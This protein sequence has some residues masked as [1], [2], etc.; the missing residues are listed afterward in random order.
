MEKNIAN[1]H[2]RRKLGDKILVTNDEGS[3]AFLSQDDYRSLLS[4]VEPSN[5]DLKAKHLLLDENNI[6]GSV[7]KTHNRYSFL[8]SG[9]PLHIIVPTLRCN[10]KCRYC[11][12]SSKK[13][14]AE[15][16]DMDEET[17][18]STVDFIM[19]SPSKT[20]II[21]FQGGEPLLNFEIVRYIIEY[22]E[23]KIPAYKTLEFRLVTNFSLMTEEIMEFLLEHKVN[24]CTSIDGP[25]EVNDNIRF[26]CDGSSAYE[27]SSY[28]L[29]KINKIYDERGIKKRVYSIVTITRS[30]LDYPKEIVDTYRDL[31]IDMLH[32]RYVNY[33]GDA[34]AA[35]KDLNYSPDEFIDYWK[36]HVEYILEL[37]KQG[38][39]VIERTIKILLQKILF[40]H[41]PNYLELR[42]P[43]GAI[44]GQMA[45]TYNGDIYTCDEG[46][47]IGEDIFRV[48][49]VKNDKFRD[50][51]GSP[52]SYAIISSSCNDCHICNYCAYKPYCGICPV[53]NYAEQGSIVGNIPATSRCKV[54]MA[55]FDY[56]FSKL[57]EG[58]EDIEIMKSWIGLGKYA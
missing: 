9:T 13:Q 53:C 35:W 14:Q 20:I 43:C 29:K 36:K 1:F 25:K 44:I 46:R 28:W 40:E 55:Q 22:A 34:S 45:Y 49:N 50:V 56:V 2:R 11:H 10:Y 58:G 48:G 19:Q 5:T 47:M 51:V 27:N 21:E 54:S 31:G 52:E 42:S 15:G 7:K 12:S 32:P 57:L 38:N 39:K 3:W 33:L 8:F 26:T 17:A 4:G 24:M 16:Y 30:C 23:K 37:N 41:D 6:A 18:K